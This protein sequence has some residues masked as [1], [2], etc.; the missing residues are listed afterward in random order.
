MRKSMSLRMLFRSPLKT[1]LTFLL[2]VSATFVLFSRVTDYAVTTRET[3]NARDFFHGVGALDN[4]VEGFEV[5]GYYLDSGN[6]PWPQKEELEAFSSLPGVTLADTR[7]MTAGLAEDYGKVYNENDIGKIML[8]GIYAGYEEKPESDWIGL[9][10]KNINVIASELDVTI[11]DTMQIGC[12]ALEDNSLG[13]NPFPQS[14]FDSLK[15]GTR[16]LLM[17]TSDSVSNYVADL[18]QNSGLY[19]RR[20]EVLRVIDGLGE[21]YLQA[22]EFDYQKKWAEVI[23]R[24]SHVFDMVYTSDMRA[25]PRFNER[26]VVMTEGRSITAEDMGTNACVVNELFLKENN[27]SIGDTVRV[28]LGDDLCSQTFYGAKDLSIESKTGF[29]DSM[30]LT[31]AGAYSMMDDAAAR[32]SEADWSYTPNAVFVP[33]SLLPVKVPDNYEPSAGEFSV[34]IE[35]AR[36]IEAFKEAAEPMVA[37]L[38][39]ALRFSDGGWGGVSDSFEI[40]FA[41]SVLTTILYIIG[42]VLALFLAVYLYI[43]RNRK[44]Y[45]IMRMLGVPGKMAARSVVLPYLVLSALAIPMGGTAGLF[46]AQDTAV[47]TFAGMAAAPEGFVL[48]TSFPI[49]VTAGCLAFEVCF[50]S[51]VAWLFLRKMK[52]TPP[53]EL[54]HEGKARMGTSKKAGE[55]VLEP[56]TVP[57]GLE[58]A[59]LSAD[60]MPADRSYGALR[61]V[62]S[63]ILRHMRGGIGKTAISLA[64]MVTVLAGMGTFVLMGLIYQDAYHQVDVRGR[65]TEFSSDMIMKLA[66]SDLVK[67]LYC[68][69]RFDVHADGAQ[70]PAPL[71]V[72]NDVERYLTDSSTVN[73]AK[74]Y[75]ASIFEGTGR[76]C[77]VGQGLAKTL[78]IQAGDEI[79]MLSGD[80]YGLLGG[81]YG[82]DK[83]YKV[84]GIVE[85]GEAEFANGIFTGIKS[86]AENIYGQPFPVGYCEFILADNDR[87]A[88]LNSLLD[89]LKDKGLKYSRMAS[90]HVDGQ[91]LKNIV[92]ICELLESLFP[93]ALL[94]TVL[95]G[96][97]A[98]FLVILQSAQEAAYLRILG[99]TKKRVRCML[100]F[101]QIVM[102]I[103]GTC[104]VTAGIVLLRPDLFARSIQTLIVC[105]GLYLLGSICGA[106]AASVQVTRHKVLEL[107]QVKE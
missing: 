58:I 18:G 45:A 48:D 34:F 38:N 84:V 20:D 104:L 87:L 24:N 83:M 12:Y 97:F 35:D 14:Y 29:A 1:L 73:Y 66:E 47:K 53:L 99:T 98:P 106:V 44:S 72:T 93:L 23:E 95:I 27:L 5:E 70:D 11:D 54:L 7:Y 30:E 21:D 43:G 50:I 8:E 13:D 102:C 101:E 85:T 39:L 107:L 74:G 55:T 51:F 19:E 17:C 46:F 52:K 60:E 31:I 77:L 26:D 69:E 28:R 33:A 75:D 10:F 56:G 90:F 22:E 94:S 37:E 81:F 4:T 59:R 63:Y 80:L 79:G 16:C 76:V 15:P 41:A 68:Y 2:V 103:A 92:R 65:A 62:S 100:A 3:E 57:V 88:D 89:G 9:K 78:N 36:D 40:G 82:T 64:M 96:V 61:H 49:G 32:R 42:A 91:V 25:I 105:F 71:T 6:K 67:D 86:S